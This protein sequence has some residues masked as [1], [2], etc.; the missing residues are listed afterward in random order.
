M[1]R[2]NNENVYEIGDAVLVCFVAVWREKYENDL[3]KRA[4][5]GGDTDAVQ[6]LEKL[7]QLDQLK[8][9]K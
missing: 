6:L 3:Q 9:K 4:A 2:N 7:A 5:E 8:F 1:L